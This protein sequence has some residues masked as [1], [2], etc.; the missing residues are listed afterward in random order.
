MLFQN[1]KNVLQK[2]ELL[3]AGG[4][5]EI[6]AIDSQRFRRLFAA[7]ANNRDTASFCRTPDWPA[8]C[9]IRHFAHQRIFGE[10]VRNVGLKVLLTDL[11]IS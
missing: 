11:F 9:D 5:P 7:F 6:I 8:P 4:G 2:V 1:G 3:V 10:E